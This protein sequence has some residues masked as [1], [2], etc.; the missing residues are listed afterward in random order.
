M[1]LWGVKE[2]VKLNIIGET[3]SLSSQQDQI[4]K[5]IDVKNEGTNASRENPTDEQIIS[6]NQIEG[7]AGGRG[8]NEYSRSRRNRGNE[9]S[10]IIN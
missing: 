7:V 4:F 3:N 6:S 1:K 2:R 5:K 8:E 10:D 9:D